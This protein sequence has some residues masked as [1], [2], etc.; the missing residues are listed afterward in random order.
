MVAFLRVTLR[1]VA[2]RLAGLRRAAVLRRV[3]LRAVAFLRVVFRLAGAA[4]FLAFLS[5]RS[6]ALARIEP[7]ERLNFFAI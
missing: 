1:L 7:G 3:V 6:A 5:P 2:L 4:F